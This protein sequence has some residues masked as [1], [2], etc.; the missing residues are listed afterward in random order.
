MKLLIAVEVDMA[1]GKFDAEEVAEYVAHAVAIDAGSLDAD[2]P[3]RKI[4]G[5]KVYADQRLVAESGVLPIGHRSPAQPKCSA[6]GKYWHNKRTCPT[7]RIPIDEMPLES[8][9]T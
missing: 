5:V 3:G 9:R 2:H 7:E 4:S 1:R 8:E 6:C